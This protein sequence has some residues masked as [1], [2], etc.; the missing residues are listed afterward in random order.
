MNE[1]IPP[2]LVMDTCCFSH[3]YMT[4][5]KRERVKGLIHFDYDALKAYCKEHGVRIAITP[6]TF[7][8]SIQTCDS[9]KMMLM[10]KEA[11][12]RAGEFWII[13]HN[14]LLERTTLGTEFLKGFDFENPEVFRKQREEWGKMVYEHLARGCFC[15]RRL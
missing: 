12:E 1:N 10:K 8:E 6:Y 15:L 11:F 2:Y 9:P 13:K 4:K 3:Y 5:E 7:Y 14:N